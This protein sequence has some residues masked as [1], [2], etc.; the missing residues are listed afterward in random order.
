VVTDWPLLLRGAKTGSARTR[1]H[2]KNN[3]ESETARGN[4]AQLCS[5]P[6]LEH[7]VRHW[8]APASKRTQ[9][10]SSFLFNNTKHLPKIKTKSQVGTKS[11]RC[12]RSSHRATSMPACPGYSGSSGPT[13]DKCFT[14]VQV[15]VPGVSRPG[16]TPHREKVLRMW[17][18][19][20]QTEAVRAD[21]G[22]SS[23]PV[24]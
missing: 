18:E 6:L 13:Q 11:Q 16:S 10:R 17:K 5:R 12:K 1:R 21:S 15:L 19:K 22:Q 3:K 7:L 4:A 23:V 8:R 24:E 9:I 20:L 14:V 2:N